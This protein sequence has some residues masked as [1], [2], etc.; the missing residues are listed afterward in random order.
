MLMKSETLTN[1][2]APNARMIFATN[3]KQSFMK[4]KLAKN[5]KFP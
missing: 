3:A 4:G 2:D 1:L 5:I